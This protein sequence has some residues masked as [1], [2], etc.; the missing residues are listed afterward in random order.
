MKNFL[1]KNL[2]YLFK[3]FLTGFKE[4]FINY[5]DPI[6]WFFNLF[7]KKQ[8]APPRTAQQIA[9]DKYRDKYQLELF[10]ELW[11]VRFKFNDEWWYLRY[12]DEDYVL[13]ET[14]E[15]CIALFDPDQIEDIITDHI[16][17]MKEGRVFLPF[18]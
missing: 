7:K 5:F 3:E 1:K 13:E 17:W 2:K 15:R 4:G 14:R 8:V 6:R 18:R 11:F 12:W 9:N 10:D 16:K